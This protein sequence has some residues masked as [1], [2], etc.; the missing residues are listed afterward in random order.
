V[1]IELDGERV[2]LTLELGEPVGQTIAL[3]AEGPGQ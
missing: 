1:L 2:D 3:F